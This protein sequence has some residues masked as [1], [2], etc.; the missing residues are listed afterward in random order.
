M[1]WYLRVF[2]IFVLVFAVAVTRQS[3]TRVE[4]TWDVSIKPEQVQ[5]ILYE[6]FQPK[7]FRTPVTGE[8]WESKVMGEPVKS[9]TTKTNLQPTE[10]QISMEGFKHYRI[11]KESY[12][13]EPIQNGV[14]I[15][16]TW[17][18]EPNPNSLSKLLFLFFSNADLNHIADGK[19]KLF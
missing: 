7:S 19:Q 1:I 13:L 3:E 8:S 9:T 11:L 18:A 12:R 5:K 6:S 15:F 4:R 2:G 14:R 16:G 10:F 17:E